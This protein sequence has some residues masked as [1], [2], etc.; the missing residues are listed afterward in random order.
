MALSD[1]ACRTA[2][3]QD[4]AYKKA[5]SGGLFLLIKPNGGKYWRMK[6]RFGGTEKLLSFGTYPLI[7]LADAR[8]MRD[9]AKR[10]LLSGTDPAS[11]K[12]H[13]KRQIIQNTQ[14]TFKAVALEWH[15]VKKN[16]WSANHAGTVLRR[17][18]KEIFPHLGTRPIA[19]IDPPELL[20]SLKRIE[21]RGALEVAARS[22]QICGQV[23][24]YG[25]QTGRC[26]RDPSAD[27]KGALKVHKT[28]HFAA[29]DIREVPELLHA[30]ELNDA[31]LYARTRRAIKLS[32]LTFVRPGELRQATWDEIDF[33]A[34]EWLIP[35]ERMK[36]KRAHIVPLSKQAIEILREQQEESGYLN[37][38]YV[39]PSQT[40]PRKPMSDGTVNVALKKL[41][42]HGRM[43]AHGFRALAR[44][45]IREKLNYEPDV[46]EAQ[47]AHKAAGPLGEAYNRAQFLDKRVVMMQ[48]WANYLDTLASQ[49]QVVK[50]RFG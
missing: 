19:D 44:T 28:E 35:A 48:D 21:K 18:E 31:R 29:I 8:E 7:S 20:E 27:L 22:K 11:V 39:F 25:I 2:K 13:E 16:G 45:A 15:E 14:N 43:N 17:L 6:Y 12:K 36:M 34:A 50:V 9:R 24:R 40:K 41:G 49:G 30:I 32:M 1:T 4:K 3:P 23:F 26:S 46:I 38:P 37:T 42:Y 47:L 10:H 5:D 33:D